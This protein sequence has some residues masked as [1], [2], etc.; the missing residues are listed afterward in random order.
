MTLALYRIDDR[1]IHGQV[2]VGWGQPLNASFIVLVDD[3]VSSSDW[4]QDLYRMG[5]PPQIEVIFASVDQA[6]EQLSTWEA[7]ERVGILLVGDIDTAVALTQ[8][9]PQV[10]RI[11]VGGVHHRTGR[12]ERLRFVY[13]TDDEAAKLRQLAARGVDVTAQDVPTARAV[14]VGEFT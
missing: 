12:R 5:V 8:R 2:V 7:D 4:E 14:P 13:L 9:A 11:N 6:A 1:L 10:R 3:E